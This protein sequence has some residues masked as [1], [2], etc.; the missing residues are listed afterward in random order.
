MK[1]YYRS[2][3]ALDD[4]VGTILAAIYQAGFTDETIVIYSSDQGYTLGEHGMMEKHYAYAV[5]GGAS[6]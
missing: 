4:A 1:S 2:S 3:Q 5:W 6:S